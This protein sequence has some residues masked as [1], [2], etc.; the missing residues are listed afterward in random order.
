VN[1][2]YA[3]LAQ[4][5]DIQRLC[6][7]LA[8][9]LDTATAEVVDGLVRSISTEEIFRRPHF[10]KIDI[11]LAVMEQVIEAGRE[12]K[13]EYHEMTEPEVYWG[14]TD[15]ASQMRTYYDDLEGFRNALERVALVRRAELLT[16]EFRGHGQN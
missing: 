5:G 11:V 4:C 13:V 15:E 8:L 9:E 3:V 16:A 7:R 12:Q 14:Y 10:A 6:A 1:A 2:V